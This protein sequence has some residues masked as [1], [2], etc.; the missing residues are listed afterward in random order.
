MKQ[1]IN[2][3]SQHEYKLFNTTQNVSAHDKQSIDKEINFWIQSLSFSEKPHIV[4]KEIAYKYKN[5][6]DSFEK[7]I[8]RCAV[9]ID[10]PHL[11]SRED[12]VDSLDTVIHDAS[13]K[14]NTLNE[15]EPKI[16]AFFEGDTHQLSSIE[17]VKFS[18]AT[19]DSK[20]KIKK[21]IQEGQKQL[22]AVNHNY[23]ER[24]PLNHRTIQMFH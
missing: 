17:K 14:L 6:I 12:I 19:L 4:L 22:H 21:L 23:A 5:W 10:N 8:V 3:Q 24:Q 18:V 13:I 20:N 2:N 9:E 11:S 1:K 7:D 15:L 16:E